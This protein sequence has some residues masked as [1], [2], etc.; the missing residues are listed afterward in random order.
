MIKVD[1]AGNGHFGGMEDGVDG[2]GQFHP[3]PVGKP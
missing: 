1:W 3:D 2:M